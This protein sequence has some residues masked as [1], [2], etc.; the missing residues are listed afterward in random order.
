MSS[1]QQ[2][3][4]ISTFRLHGIIVKGQ[5][6]ASTPVKITAAGN[7]N[8]SRSAQASGGGRQDIAITRPEV[9]TIGSKDLFVKV[10]ANKRTVHEQEPVLLTYKVY[11]NVNLVRM[12]GKMP[13]IK[14]SH[15]QEITLPQ[16]KVFRT[17]KLNGRHLSHHNLEPV[18]SLS[19]GNRQA[20]CAFRNLYRTCAPQ[21]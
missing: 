17:E 12:A 15:V 10:T 5:T 3:E 6:L 1:W 20:S 8:I 18:C 11:T 21:Y 9:K 14:G 2:S 19:A 7:A 16:Q 4:A 13:D